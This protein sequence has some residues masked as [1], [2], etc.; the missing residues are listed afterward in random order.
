[1]ADEKKFTLWC[2]K[3][4]EVNTDPQ[5]RC[6]NGCHFSS[7]MVWT[8]WE[9]LLDYKTEEAGEDTMKTFQRI[10]PTHQYVL[11]PYG[12]DPNKTLPHS[13]NPVLTS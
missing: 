2:R 10:N 6:Y 9:D 13:V 7:E 1:M 5:R 12:A 8:R 4:I 11:L 3:K